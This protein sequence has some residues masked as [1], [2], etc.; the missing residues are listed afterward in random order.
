MGGA[1]LGSV[2]PKT[3]IL[4]GH[5]KDH[6]PHRVAKKVIILGTCPSRELAPIED[7][8]WEVWTIGPGGKNV[9]RWERLFELHGAASWPQGFRHYL[10]E[11]K[12]VKP[13]RII[14]TEAAM[15]DW[16]AS[17]VINRDGLF[18]KYGRMWFQSQISYALAVALEENVTA[19]G[20]Y[21]IDLEAGEEYRSQFTSA[22][23]FMNLAQ[24]AGI[25]VIVPEGCGLL[26]DPNPYP[27]T[28]ETHLAQTLRSKSDHL[29]G[30]LNMKMQQVEQLKLEIAQ[31]NGEVGMCEFLRSLYVIGG[32]DPSEPK[33]LQEETLSEKV[34]RIDLMIR[35]MADSNSNA[36]ARDPAL[37]DSL[38]RL[39]P[40]P[41]VVADLHG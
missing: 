34:E 17:Q 33:P 31:L 7:K 32:V 27:D 3:V 28:W 9:Q 15:P 12:S 26:R 2:P 39:P 5:N 35:G 18:A 23:Y 16:P 20:I 13:P 21:G 36:I 24:L 11:L 41:N 22:K 10:E 14:Y 19:I 38:E 1:D 30:L 37:D 25:D 29:Q 40:A 4:R 6:I 8:T